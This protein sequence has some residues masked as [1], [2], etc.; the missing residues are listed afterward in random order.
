MFPMV[1][2]GT[3]TQRL[4]HL[5]I[6]PE[7][8]P[9]NNN[10]KESPWY[11]KSDASKKTPLQSLDPHLHPASRIFQVLWLSRQVGGAAFEAHRKQKYQRRVGTSGCTHWS[12]VSGGTGV[13]VSGGTCLLPPRV[14]QTIGSLKNAVRTG[15]FIG[16]TVWCMRQYC[17]MAVTHPQAQV[18]KPI[19]AQCDGGLQ[20]A[21][22]RVEALVAVPLHAEKLNVLPGLGALLVLGTG[23]S[24][25]TACIS[26][27][28]QVQAE[29]QSWWAIEVL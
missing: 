2:V 6:P 24:G 19:K 22:S 1:H 12:E 9:Q 8:R 11:P 29:N 13:L 10:M 3:L 18:T 26:P 7:A 17:E 14:Q 28:G 25:G 4:W 27:P 20:L 21:H 5:L 16:H 15:V 23:R